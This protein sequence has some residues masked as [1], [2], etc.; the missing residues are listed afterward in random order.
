MYMLCIL[1]LN[2]FF[3][4]LNVQEVRINIWLLVTIK[5]PWNHKHF[6][7]IL[8]ETSAYDNKLQIKPTP[9]QLHSL[10]I[11][12]CG[13]PTMGLWKFTVSCC[14]GYDK[15]I[16]CFETK[17]IFLD[18]CSCWTDIMRNLSG[19]SFILSHFSQSPPNALDQNL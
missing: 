1:T 5:T 6:Y 3:C 14:G 17:W 19:S 18:N 12:T 15:V 8:L 4:M 10:Y 11:T 16:A 9:F 7:Y 2:W 13:S